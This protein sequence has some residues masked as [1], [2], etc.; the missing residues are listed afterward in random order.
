MAD[1][2]LPLIVE[3]GQPKPVFWRRMAAI[4]KDLR[5]G[6]YTVK[7]GK[8]QARPSDPQRA[9]YFAVIVAMVAE[10]TG[11]TKDQTHELLKAKF[12]PKDSDTNGVLVGELVVGGSIT[13][14]NRGGMTEFIEDIRGWSEG[15]LGCPIPP[16][17]PNWKDLPE[18][19]A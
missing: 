7:V 14:L 11:Y 19:A 2:I 9:Y 12:L 10:E 1:Q 17:D 4:C 15:F 16:P 5:D 8:K 13:K 18:V 3:R 6:E